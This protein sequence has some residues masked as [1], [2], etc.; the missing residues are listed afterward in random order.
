MFDYTIVI[1][2]NFNFGT[3][4]QTEMKHENSEKYYS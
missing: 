3:Y 2:F 1:D 4:Q